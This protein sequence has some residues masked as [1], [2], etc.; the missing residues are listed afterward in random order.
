VMHEVAVGSQR[1]PVVGKENLEPSG[2]RPAGDVEAVG[3]VESPLVALD[4]YCPVELSKH[5]RWV[6]GDRRWPAVHR[7]RRY[8]FSGPTQREQFLANPDRYAPACSGCDPVLLADGRRRVLGQTD[9]C[10]IYNRRLY[11]F[12]SLVTVT[13]FQKDPKRY[14]AD[15]QE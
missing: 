3:Q 5:E 12:S 10:V 1:T 7:G 2:E 4:G 15:G 13:R 14:V 11:M 6:P 8:L 9:Y